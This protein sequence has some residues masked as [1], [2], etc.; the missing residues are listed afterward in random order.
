MTIA[1]DNSVYCDQD[2]KSR[3]IVSPQVSRKFGFQVWRVSEGL[4]RL[5]DVEFSPIPE[6]F[7][8]GTNVSRL[9]KEMGDKIIIV[10]RPF[11]LLGWRPGSP[12][13]PGSSTSIFAVGIEDDDVYIEAPG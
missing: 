4:E 8:I 5:R 9:F 7:A 6:S 10:G 2:G 1:Q 3:I 13:T 11:W 12:A